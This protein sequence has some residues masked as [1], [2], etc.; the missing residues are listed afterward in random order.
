VLGA[1]TIYLVHPPQLNTEGYTRSLK[2]ASV[3]YGSKAFP[4][5]YFADI[6]GY[7]RLLLSKFFYEAFT[8]HEFMLLYQL[9]AFVFEDRLPEWCAKGYSYIGA[10]WFEGFIPPVEEARLWKVGNGGFT[11]RRIPDC[12]RVFEAFAVLRPWSSIV[13]EHFQQHSAASW[14]TWPRLG[15][16]LL[17]GN[18]THWRFNDYNRYAPERQEDFYWGVECTEKFSWYTVPSPEEA[19]AFSFEVH[20]SLM[21]ELNGHRIPMGCHAWEKYEPTFWEPLIDR[22]SQQH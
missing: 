13:R 3:P 1:Y 6:F 12:L 2:A 8:A 20:P 9:D 10:P 19:L 4:A 22:Y 5:V 11:L 21:Y 16:R 17:L 18:N 14:K 15:K 7:N